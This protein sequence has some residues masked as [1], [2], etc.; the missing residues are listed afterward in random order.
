M[1]EAGDRHGKILSVAE[2]FRR[3]P[4]NRLAH[5]LIHDGAIGTPRLMVETSI[6]GG[7]RLLITPWRHQKLRGTVAL[8]VGVHNADILQYY[9]GDATS[10]YGIS[11][12]TSS[13][14]TRTARAARV[15]S[16][17]SGMRTYRT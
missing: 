4:V 8:D 13:I 3:D 1:I 10:A 16:T 17:R 9:M 15:D 6:G 12:S 7:N 2:N 14:V 5:A 11:R